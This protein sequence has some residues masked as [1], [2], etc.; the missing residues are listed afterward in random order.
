MTI[1]T[2]ISI[3]GLLTCL[4][5]GAICGCSI[6]PYGGK[7]RTSIITPRMRMATVSE[8]GA[9]ASKADSAEQQ[10]ICENLAR[11]IQ[12]EPDPLVRQEIQ[13]TV[14]EFS[15]PLAEKMLIAGLSDEDV[16]VRLT[17][18]FRLGER[19][20]VTTIGPLQQAVQSDSELDVRLAAIDALA[21]IPGQATVPALGAALDD[22]DPAIQY[23]AVQALKSASGKDLGNDVAAWQEYVASGASV[24]PEVSVAERIQ[25]A[26]PF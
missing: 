24:Q 1:R 19:A 21:N 11:Q 8:I 12:T 6:F 3:R 17:C 25:Q 23:A 4:L 14:A 9:R 22:R 18:C 13:N 20:S 7:E 10:Q 16:D 26:S 2:L 15:A 5:A